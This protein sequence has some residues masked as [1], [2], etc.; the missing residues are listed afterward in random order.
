MQRPHRQKFHQP[1]KL[2]PETIAAA[3]NSEGHKPA[4][5]RRLALA[6]AAHGVKTWRQLSDLTAFEVLQFRTLG[7]H[8]VKFARLQL[9]KRGLAF[10]G[11]EVPRL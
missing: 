9:A 4:Q 7:E 2:P 8:S 5:A 3:I 1:L 10:K 11:E 6:C